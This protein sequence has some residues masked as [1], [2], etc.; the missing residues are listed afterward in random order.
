LFETDMEVEEVAALPA[1]EKRTEFRPEQL[2]Q[3]RTTEL[4]RQHVAQGVDGRADGFRAQLD[5]VDVLRVTK[6]LAKSSLWIGVPPRRV[7]ALA[8][9]NG[10]RDSAK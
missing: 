10:D 5:E 4:P 2:F 9:S 3:A 1:L 8:P 6:R 7:N